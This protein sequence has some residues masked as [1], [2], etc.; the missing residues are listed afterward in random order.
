MTIFPLQIRWHNFQERLGLF[1]NDLVGR[2]SSSFSHHSGLY[3][4]NGLHHTFRL[5]KLVINICIF[6]HSE[7]LRVISDG[8][9]IHIQDIILKG[10]YIG[11]VVSF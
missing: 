9:L 3:G 7:D 10:A 1:H 8:E 5:L 2:L 6:V 4:Q 11:N